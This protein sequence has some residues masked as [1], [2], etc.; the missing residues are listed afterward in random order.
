[1]VKTKTLIFTC[2]LNMIMCDVFGNSYYNGLFFNPRFLFLITDIETIKPSR[3]AATKVIINA[4]YMDET[5]L[6]LWW[7][8]LL[9]LFMFSDGLLA[10][11]ARLFKKLLTYAS[12]SNC[13][14]ILRIKWLEE[15]LSK[16]A[17]GGQ[18][19]VVFGQKVSLTSPTL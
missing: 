13:A 2:F 11:R 9:Q 12:F 3:A 6:D 4:R 16:V 15:R 8:E 18:A 7:S 14:G 19:R 17:S 5:L 10:Q 1:M